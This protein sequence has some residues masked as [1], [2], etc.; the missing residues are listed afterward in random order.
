MKVQRWNGKQKRG[1]DTS[2]ALETR[3]YLLTVHQEKGLLG[4]KAEADNKETTSGIQ[5][6]VLEEYAIL[7]QNS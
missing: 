5:G 7:L 6:T 3:Q 1:Y 2:I 4:S